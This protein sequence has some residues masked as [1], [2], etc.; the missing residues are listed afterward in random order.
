M[1]RPKAATSF[2]SSLLVPPL[3]HKC[4]FPSC[5]LV[6]VVFGKPHS[7]SWERAEKHLC[8]LRV[9]EFYERK[10]NYKMV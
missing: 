9:C 1:C 10:S 5:Y 4:L 8:R 6:L 2:S 3:L 7:S